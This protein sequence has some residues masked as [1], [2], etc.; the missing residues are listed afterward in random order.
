MKSIQRRKSIFSAS[1]SSAAVPSPPSF[2]VSRVDERT[3]QVR[4]SSLSVSS[5]EQQDGEESPSPPPSLEET[6]PNRLS[7]NS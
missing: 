5:S 2:V 4:L 7:D 3:L 6:A 1:A